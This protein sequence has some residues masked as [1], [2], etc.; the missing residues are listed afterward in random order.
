MFSVSKEFFVITC[1]GGSLLRWRLLKIVVHH[2][3]TQHNNPETPLCSA[4]APTMRSLVK[5]F[6]LWLY[7]LLLLL[8]PTRIL[9]H[10]YLPYSSRTGDFT[11]RVAR[12]QICLST[13][14]Q[15]QLVQSNL[16]WFLQSCTAHL[17]CRSDC[18]VMN[19][20]AHTRLGCSMET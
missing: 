20:S 12:G 9:D 1:F 19:L 11:L 13:R 14:P 4:Y 10:S 16:V 5:M 7:P 15:A 3:S 17:A 6:L 8:Q 18:Q 2:P